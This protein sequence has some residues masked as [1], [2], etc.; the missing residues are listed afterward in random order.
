MT[1]STSGSDNKLAKKKC[2]FQVDGMQRD[3]MDTL[4]DY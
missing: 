3:T 1:R 2:Y 4:H